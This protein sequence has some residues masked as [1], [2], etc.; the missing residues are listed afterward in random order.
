MRPIEGSSPDP[1]N[2]PEGCS[3]HPRC[4]L[5]DEMC[6]SRNPD[7]DEVNENHLAACFHWE[8]S[9]EAVPFDLR[10]SR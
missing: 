5:A 4:P 3:Y 1:V 2:V 10:G 8:Q 9:E 6:L 7:L